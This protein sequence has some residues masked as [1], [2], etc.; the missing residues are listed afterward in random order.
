MLQRL[1]GASGE[2]RCKLLEV[3]TLH[4]LQKK[5]RS[6][7][8]FFLLRVTLLSTVP[9][10]FLKAMHCFLLRPSF[11]RRIF[12]WV[13]HAPEPDILHMCEVEECVECVIYIY[14]Y[15]W[16]LRYTL[17]RIRFFCRISHIL[18]IASLIKSKKL[19]YFRFRLRTFFGFVSS[20]L[21]TVILSINDENN[22]T[23]ST[24]PM[25]LVQVAPPKSYRVF[26]LINIVDG[27]NFLSS[28]LG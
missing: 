2:A 19:F 11:L 10:A 1:K 14:C 22:D 28:R 4:Q 12:K 8:H 9:S 27:F 21:N 13:S 20:I 24:Q 17:D 5:S 3:V 26:I 18:D 16:F 25:S 6:Y 7:I 23:L 15:C